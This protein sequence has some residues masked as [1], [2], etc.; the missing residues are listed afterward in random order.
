MTKSKVWFLRRRPSHDLN[1]TRTAIDL[2]LPGDLPVER[3]AQSRSR[4]AANPIVTQEVG[5]R[6][7]ESLPR[8]SSPVGAGTSDQSPPATFASRWGRSQSAPSA[9]LREIFT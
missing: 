7:S 3:G 6:A 4:V 8:A 5:I 2:A 1:M 9:P